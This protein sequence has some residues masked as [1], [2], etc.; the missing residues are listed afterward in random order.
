M[1]YK[2][3]SYSAFVGSRL[4]IAERP[5]E[6]DSHKRSFTLHSKTHLQTI[7]L[8]LFK[9]IKMAETKIKKR[10]H[11]MELPNLSEAS[12]AFFGI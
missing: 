2:R 10:T 12:V 11:V 3:N 8:M 1:V 6:E 7:G 5:R 9:R 4:S